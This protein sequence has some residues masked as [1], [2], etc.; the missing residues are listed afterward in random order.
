MSKYCS[1]NPK[2]N[3]I[4]PDPQHWLYTGTVYRSRHH[5]SE[6]IV[7]KVCR[8]EPGLAG[9]RLYYTGTTYTDPK[10]VTVF[11]L[12]VTFVRKIPVLFLHRYLNKK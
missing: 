11:Q 10:K 5:I 3:L 2:P 7:Y 4:N 9:N 12:K 1:L 8:I 6:L